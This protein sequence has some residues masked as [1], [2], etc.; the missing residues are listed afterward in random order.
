MGSSEDSFFGYLASLKNRS[1]REPEF[2]TF[3]LALYL[4]GSVK[5]WFTSDLEKW[6]FQSQVLATL[7]RKRCQEIH[8]QPVKIRFGLDVFFM[9]R[10]WSW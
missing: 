6:F 3:F 2:Q 9:S 8:K 1:L 5:I 4:A 7:V 10:R